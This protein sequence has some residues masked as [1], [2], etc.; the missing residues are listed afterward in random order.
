MKVH[1]AF[2]AGKN[3]SYTMLTRDVG[4]LYTRLPEGV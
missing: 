3:I 4:D 1:N 2:S